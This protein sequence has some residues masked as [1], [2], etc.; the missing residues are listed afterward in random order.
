MKPMLYQFSIDGQ[1][2]ECDLQALQ[3]NINVDDVNE[4][5]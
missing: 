4:G 2:T 1:S 5:E 3:L